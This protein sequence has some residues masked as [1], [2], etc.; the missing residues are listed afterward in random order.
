M[1]ELLN[2][3]VNIP[4]K[5]INCFMNPQFVPLG[6]TVGMPVHYTCKSL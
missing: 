2:E 1:G 3:L 4:G 6:Y 5:Y